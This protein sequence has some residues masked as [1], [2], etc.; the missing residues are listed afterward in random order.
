VSCKFKFEIPRTSF[1]TMNFIRIS[2]LSDM[3]ILRLVSDHQ[4]ILRGRIVD[5]YTRFG[6]EWNGRR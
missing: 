1:A 3:S 5:S 4:R 2:S 6:L